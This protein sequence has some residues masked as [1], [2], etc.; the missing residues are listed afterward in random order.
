MKTVLVTGANGFIAQQLAHK[1]AQMG[2]RVVGLAR[3]EGNTGN[4]HRLYR[5]ALLESAA[6]VFQK[7]RVAAVV[8]AANDEGANAYQT[9]V[10]GTLKWF[11]EGQSA[12]V[13]LQILLSSLSAHA[14]AASDYGRAKFTLEQHFISHDHV[15]FR[16]GGRL[17]VVSGVVHLRFWLVGRPHVV[18]GMVHLVGLGRGPSLSLGDHLLDGLLQTRL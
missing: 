1:L 13:P 7:E 17:H 8:H 12:G 6:A 4:F 10:E 14:D 11:A 18:S 9:N 16:L 5:V 2:Y 3:H 15:A